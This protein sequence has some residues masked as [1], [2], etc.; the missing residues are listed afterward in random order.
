M[1]SQLGEIYVAEL[2]SWKA[3][4]GSVLPNSIVLQESDGCDSRPFKEGQHTLIVESNLAHAVAVIRQAES[5]TSRQRNLSSQ[6][7]EMPGR[8][9]GESMHT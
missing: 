3:I 8:A 5:K 1:I 4:C 6:S 2:Q 7:S 9:S